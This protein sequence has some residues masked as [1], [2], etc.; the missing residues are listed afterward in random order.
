MKCD[1]EAKQLRDIASKLP[2]GQMNK[3]FTLLLFFLGLISCENNKPQEK[4]SNVI[5][6][7]WVEIIKDDY[8]LYKPSEPINAVLILFG[9]Y[10]EVAA[11]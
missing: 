6:P 4:Q 3:S 9:G 11:S 7:E 1:L 8:E 2:T 10:P 5:E